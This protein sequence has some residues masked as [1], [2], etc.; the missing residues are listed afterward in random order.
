MDLGTIIIGT[1]M[2]AICLMP[3]VLMSRSRKNKEK[4]I[5]R[6][7]EKAA[8][9][10]GGRISAYDINLTIGIGMDDVNRVVYFSRLIGGRETIQQVSLSDVQSCKVIIKSK[11]NAVYGGTIIE[12]L[13]LAF[14]LKETKKGGFVYE[15]FDAIENIQ[16]NGELQLIEKWQ[17]KITT[18]L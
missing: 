8:L 10:N 1:I 17:Q 11:V 4:A 18:H 3:F 9:E 5:S 7:L 2:I 13:T 15:F 12:K 6:N 16:L 14:S